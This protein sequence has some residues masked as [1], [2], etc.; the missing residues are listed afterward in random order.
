MLTSL[1]LQIMEDQF[2]QGACYISGVEEF[3]DSSFISNEKNICTF[4]LD[5]MNSKDLYYQMITIN[6]IQTK[7]YK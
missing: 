7:K 5:S 1:K 2:D 3:F 4:F 6:S